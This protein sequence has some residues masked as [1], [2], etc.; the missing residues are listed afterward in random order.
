M[1]LMVKKNK[2]NDD[3]GLKELKIWKGRLLD[4]KN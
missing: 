2:P 1:V 4:E 3:S